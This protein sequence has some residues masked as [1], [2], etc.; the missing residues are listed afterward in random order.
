MRF[1]APGRLGQPAAP[2]DAT[3]PRAGRLVGAA[4]LAAGFVALLSGAAVAQAC[5]PAPGEMCDVSATIDPRLGGISISGNGDVI[6]GTGLAP[7]GYSQALTYDRRSGDVTFLG[8]LYVSRDVSRAGDVNFDGSVVAGTTN[9]DLPNAFRW[10]QETGMVDLGNLI[11]AG[12]ITRAF[13]VNAAGDVVVGDATSVQG[14]RHAFRWTDATGMVDLGTLRSGNLGRSEARAVSD[15]GTVVVGVSDT[16]QTDAG[17]T[18]RFG[19]RWTP[20]SGMEKLVAPTVGTEGAARANDV[21][22]DGRIVVGASVSIAGD[23]ATI[24]RPGDLKGEYLGTLAETTADSTY[25]EALA[26]NDDGSVIVG[27]SDISDDTQHAFIW[28][29]SEVVPGSTSL[30]PDGMQDLGTLAAGNSGRS[31]ATDVTNDG[32]VV[33][34]SAEN[35]AGEM[36]AFIWRADTMLDHVNTGVAVQQSA[37]ALAATAAHYGQ[38]TVYQLGREVA[39]RGPGGGDGARVSSQ[40]NAAQQMPVAVRFGG[41]LAHTE[42]VATSGGAEVTAAIGLTPTLTLGGFVEI[43]DETDSHSVVSLDGTH[44][45]GGASLRYRAAPDGTGL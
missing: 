39:L 24:W 35:D 8:A 43:M 21:S 23:I 11:P 4:G 32:T 15:S 10:S 29:S 16:D 6:A 14:A 38:N 13:G 18:R 12:G 28:R 31:V 2:R 36:R 30:E 17:S 41:R 9:E 1:P 22:G 5:P 27:V 19:F 25:S 20:E 40:G 37:Q 34:G 33:V 45:A 7:V 26:V 44:I 3:C 42:D